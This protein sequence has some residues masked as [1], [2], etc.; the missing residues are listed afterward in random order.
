MAARKSW[1]I[2]FYYSK[3]EFINGPCEVPILACRG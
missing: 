2:R 3:P 1:S